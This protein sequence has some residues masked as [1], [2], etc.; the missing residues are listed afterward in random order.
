[1]NKLDELSEFLLECQKHI[2]ARLNR[3][4]DLFTAAE[5]LQQLKES[6]T[7]F[8]LENLHEV[9]ACYN[10][11]MMAESRGGNSPLEV[12]DEEIQMLIECVCGYRCP[13]KVK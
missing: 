8:E 1:M 12:E 3:K 9:K 10:Y 4:T 5:L 13:I 6:V 2:N 7:V 11:L